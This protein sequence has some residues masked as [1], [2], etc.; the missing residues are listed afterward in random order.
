[1]PCSRLV[2][3]EEQLRRVRPILISGTVRVAQEIAFVDL[4]SDMQVP[5]RREQSARRWAQFVEQ[6]KDMGIS[7]SSE[8]KEVRMAEAAA[9]DQFGPQRTVLA[10]SS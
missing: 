2:K 1:M 4:V 9:H 8:A 7:G 10:G 6:M 5:S 3:F